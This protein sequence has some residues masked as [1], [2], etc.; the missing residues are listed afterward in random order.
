MES[1][2]PPTIHISRQQARSFLL[3]YHG[4]AGTPRFLGNEGI[5]GFIR[6]AGCIQ[7]DPVDGCG[8]NADLVLQSRIPEYHPSWLQTELYEKRTLIDYYDKNMAI[9]PIEDWKYFARTR[10]R[11]LNSHWISQEV[12]AAFPQVRQELERN[13][14]ILS[15]QDARIE[16]NVDWS[17]AP[18][19]LARAALESLYFQGELIIHHRTGTVRHYAPAEEY[20]PHEVISAQEP[21]EDDADYLCWH[22]LRRIASV[23]LLWNK[24]SDAWLAIE[25]LNA[26]AR[27]AAFLKLEEN[28]LIIPISIE[29]IKE[30]LYIPATSR[31]L[32]EKQSVLPALQE[33]I[34]FIAP[35]DN[36]MWD[37]T[38]IQRLFNFSYTWEIYTPPAKRKYG[39]YTLPVLSGTSFAG[40]IEMAAQRKDGV[41]LIKNFWP[42]PSLLELP[43][44]QQKRFFDLMQERLERFALFND[45]R[46]LTGEELL[47]I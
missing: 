8:R 2:H 39:W 43:R 5:H 13:G 9:F 4:L 33:R 17:W 7:F 27:N 38:L 25:G 47:R 16:G 18:A 41:L 3:S 14:G 10:H 29:G 31:D 6:Q 15:S 28:G 40:R 21:H 42:E 1:T 23:G 45:C 37:R 11:Y 35:L 30:P 24:R 12:R 34:E 22:L 32:L 36:I 19:R 46:S 20:L 26:Q 44:A